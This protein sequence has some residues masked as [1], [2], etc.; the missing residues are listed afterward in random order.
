MSRN[1]EDGSHQL[2]LHNPPGSHDIPQQK[3]YKGVIEYGVRVCVMSDF[4]FQQQEGPPG[5]KNHKEQR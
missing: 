3:T 2:C 1:D 4:L 5:N